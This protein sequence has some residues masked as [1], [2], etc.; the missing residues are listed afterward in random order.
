M[1]PGQM[2]WAR[3]KNLSLGGYEDEFFMPFCYKKTLFPSA[4]RMFAT[5]PR[6]AHAS[7]PFC[8]TSAPVGAP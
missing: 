1:V 3:L 5:K 7:G 8:A 4:N 6:M 2:I